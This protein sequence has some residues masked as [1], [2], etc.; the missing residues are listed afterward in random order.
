VKALVLLFSCVSA[1]GAQVV[2]EL[3][4]EGD[5][6]DRE[7]RNFEAV[8]LYLK[9]DAQKP[10]EAG[11]LWR[12]SKQY[13][14]LMMDAEGASERRRQKA[15]DAA[16]RAVSADPNDSQAHLSLAI[17][18][19]RIALNEPPRRKVELSRLIRREAETAARLD[20]TNDYAW[21]VLGRWN[22][23]VA[24]FNPVL[25]ALAQAVYGKLPDA[26]NEKAVEYFT[27]AI[28]LQPQRVIHRLELG[29]TYLAIGQRQKARDA[30]NKGISLPSIEKDDDNH[31]ARAREV[32]RQLQ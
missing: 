31:K 2:E 30:F 28:A 11:I 22:Y 6:M 25:K 9:A 14:Q 19:G 20:A 16:Q 24:N 29:R 7:N 13:A 18:Y 5:A 32:L 8:A 10:R 26:S 1:L 21:H 23:E 17:V 15:L 3:I 12:L 27:K 4:A